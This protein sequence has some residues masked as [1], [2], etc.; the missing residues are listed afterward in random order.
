MI[1]RNKTF[2]SVVLKSALHSINHPS[3]IWPAITTIWR[4]FFSRRGDDASRTLYIRRCLRCRSC[5]VFHKPTRSCGAP[6]AD[7][8]ELGCWCFVWYKNKLKSA[9]CWMRDNCEYHATK[10]YSWPTKLM[11]R[12]WSS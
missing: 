12:K 7:R 9:R 6:G 8:P 5:P 10:E 4:A 11:R 2:A 1:K 3:K